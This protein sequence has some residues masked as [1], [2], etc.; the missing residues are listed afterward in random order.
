MSE[1]KKQKNIE[2]K[3]GGQKLSWFLFFF[4][5]FLLLPLGT[6]NFV[7]ADDTIDGLN[8]QIE[9]KK[10]HLDQINRRIDSYQDEINQLR[11]E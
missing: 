8:N 2:K 6:T 9:E 1:I 10:V 3:A 11:S 5:S 4:F 7:F